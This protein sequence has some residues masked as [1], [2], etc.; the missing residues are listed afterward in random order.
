MS[1]NACPRCQEPVIAARMRE[2]RGFKLVSLE[3]CAAG[4][5]DVAL[6][7]S[8]FN[9]GSAPLAELVSNGTSYR[10]HRAHGAFTGQ[11]RSQKLK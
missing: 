1:G 7:Q 11:G 3:R 5:G 4:A 9:D 10:A 2:G 6:V 8:L